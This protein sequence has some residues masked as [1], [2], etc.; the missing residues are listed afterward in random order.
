MKAYGAKQAVLDVVRI[1]LQHLEDRDFNFLLSRNLL[2]GI[3]L[4]DIVQWGR[5]SGKL[6]TGISLFVKLLS[7]P[8]LLAKISILKRY[9]DKAWKHYLEY[10]E[11]P[12]DFEKWREEG[13]AI[14][15]NF[16]KA[17]NLK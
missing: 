11:S 2:G 4:K 15:E 8:S 5:L 1:Y 10:P 16:K 3:D 6:L 7:K 14:F 13:N 12:K 9:M 17:L